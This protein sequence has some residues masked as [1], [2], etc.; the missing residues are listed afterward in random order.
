MFVSAVR[1]VRFGILTSGGSR[2]FH[3]L[4][5]LGFWKNIKIPEF[6][7]NKELIHKNEPFGGLEPPTCSLRMS[8]STN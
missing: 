4:E 1:H 3:I 7:Q 6:K 2:I 5:E 8:C